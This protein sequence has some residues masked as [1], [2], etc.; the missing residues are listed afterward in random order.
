[1]NDTKYKGDV[2]EAAVV[3][4]FIKAGYTV[5]IPHG[6][7]QRYDLIVEKDGLMQRVQCKTA[8]I[9]NNEAIEFNC[10]NGNNAS[11]NGTSDYRGDVELFATYNSEINEVFIIPV[12]ACG[13]ST[14]TLRLTENNSN[15]QKGIRWAKDY[16]LNGRNPAG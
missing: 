13:I 3:L 1:M 10:C 11:S 6:E 14:C 9:H 5:C 12:D 15:Q 4:E 8:R 16:K 2:T 7:N